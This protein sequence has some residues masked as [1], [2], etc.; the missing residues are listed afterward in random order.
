MRNAAQHGMGR[1]IGAILFGGMMLTALGCGDGPTEPANE[2]LTMTEAIALLEGMREIQQDTTARILAASEDSIVVACPV[3]GQVRVSG[4]ASESATGDTVRLESD[5]TAA[6]AGCQ[7]SQSDLDFTVDGDPGI[8]ERTNLVIV[9][10]F[11]HFSID[12]TVTG[13]VG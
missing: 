1:R 10:F 7:F 6:P 8:R 2:P 5:F 4:R 12:G 3:A 9:G 13:S 11:E